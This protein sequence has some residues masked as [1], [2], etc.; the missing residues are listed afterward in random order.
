[1]PLICSDIPEEFENCHTATLLRKDVAES[2]QGIFQVN[3]LWM[4]I[5]SK[6][7]EMKSKVTGWKRVINLLTRLQIWKLSYKA[8]CRN[9]VCQL[10]IE[11]WSVTSWTNKNGKDSS[12]TANDVPDLL[13]NTQQHYIFLFGRPLL[14]DN[15]AIK[16]INIDDC[17]SPLCFYVLIKL[18]FCALTRSRPWFSYSFYY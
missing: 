8:F 15:I 10:I 11:E 14:F 12:C 1:M 5:L 4:E 3:D 6:P 18:F 16:H 9:L 7:K 2:P 17:L 13:T